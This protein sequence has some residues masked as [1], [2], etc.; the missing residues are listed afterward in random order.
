MRPRSGAGQRAHPP[1][2]NETTGL[3]DVRVI[4]VR[5]PDLFRKRAFIQRAD[6]QAG[7]AAVGTERKENFLAN[8]GSE[9]RPAPAGFAG[10]DQTRKIR[11]Q[12]KIERVA[13]V[14]ATPE[15]IVAGFVQFP[16][17]RTHLVAFGSMTISRSPEPANSPSIS[18]PFPMPRTRQ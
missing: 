14:D 12:A 4:Q 11:W 17:E 7:D 9:R 2:L 3:R 10:H 16:P 6:V 15:A 5:V 1:K 13:R 8:S 18:L